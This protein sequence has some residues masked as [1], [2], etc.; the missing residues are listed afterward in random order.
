MKVAA[1]LL[2]ERHIKNHLEKPPECVKVPDTQY[3][4]IQLF[5]LVAWA[6][7]SLQP[8]IR[9][10]DGKIALVGKHTLAAS[11]SSSGCSM[12]VGMRRV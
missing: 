11:S 7:S 2:N 6:Q 1:S 4:V 3:L 10:R 5:R 12:M 8:C 9:R